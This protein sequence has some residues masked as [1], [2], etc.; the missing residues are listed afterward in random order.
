MP[1]IVYLEALTFFVHLFVEDPP[2]IVSGEVLHNQTFLQYIV[3]TF[4]QW[5]KNYEKLQVRPS[6]QI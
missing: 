4:T 2:P 3:C 5:K 6:H 1:R